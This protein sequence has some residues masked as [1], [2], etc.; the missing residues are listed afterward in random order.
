VVHLQD[1]GKEGTM[2]QAN[3]GHVWGNHMKM[4]AKFSGEELARIDNLV[5]ERDRIFFESIAHPYLDNIRELELYA[6]L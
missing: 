4:E 6:K 2:S 5:E 1:A 3:W